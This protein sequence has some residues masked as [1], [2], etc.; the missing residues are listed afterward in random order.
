[1]AFD[2]SV[3]LCS[4]V[5]KA[6]MEP[7]FGDDAEVEERCA[8]RV[9]TPVAE[10]GTFTVELPVTTARAPV[11]WAGTVAITS[12]W[13][14][15]MHWRSTSAPI[16][17]T[18]PTAAAVAPTVRRDRIYAGEGT[19]ARAMFPG[20]LPAGGA[21]TVAECG[22]GV[23]AAP[24]DP[25]AVDAACPPAGRVDVPLDRVGEAVADVPG[26]P[27]TGAVW[28]GGPAEDGGLLAGAVP[29]V[30]DDPRLAI[31]PS[32]RHIADGE[33]V[34][35]TLDQLT[36][37]VTDGWR[38][39][40]CERHILDTLPTPEAASLA[41]TPGIPLGPTGADGGLVADYPVRRVVTVAE[42][43]V[44]R[45]DVDCSVPDA[46]IVLVVGRPQDE[47]ADVGFG[48]PIA[49]EAAPPAV[50]PLAARVDEGDAGGVTAEVPIVLSAPA[51]YPV[52]VSWTTFDVP[53]LPWVAR[54][55]ADVA[56]AEGTVT[57][58]PGEVAA[59]VPLEVTGD[60]EAEADE[61]ALI[62]VHAP[63]GAT[64]GGFGGIGGVTIVDD[65]RA[66]D[67]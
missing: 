23:L 17:V 15:D 50:I 61:M 38:G 20:A 51:S 32:A 34:T 5:P 8:A 48:A 29:F 11:V 30:V 13:L 2:P 67:G 9:T 16:A 28:V 46:C 66:A 21:V 37:P 24:L 54:V 42:G 1:L 39:H 52:T 22:A 6:D 12:V 56:A 10:D 26:R 64:V 59:T 41:C 62:G 49:V 4:E 36:R 7:G 31:T 27:G 53:D 33:V 43:T 14:L 47:V 60:G 65:D 19:Q 57:F 63:H 55:G 3:A 45:R 25:A 40:Q 58:A 44:A 35:L 18:P